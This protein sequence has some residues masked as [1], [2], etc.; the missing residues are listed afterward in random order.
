MVA[1]EEDLRIV[2]HDIVGFQQRR[3]PVIT[4][5]NLV[6]ALTRLH[7]LDVLGHLPRQQ[8]KTNIVPSAWSRFTASARRL[9]AS[10]PFPAVSS[11]MSLSSPA[12]TAAA[13]R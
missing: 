6:G 2:A 11:R 4:A 7:Y 1:V 8:E 9:S 3:I 12:I 5:E 13:R 10:G